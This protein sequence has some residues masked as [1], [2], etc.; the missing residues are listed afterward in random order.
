MS[1]RSSLIIIS[2]FLVAVIFVSGC[3]SSDSG[4]VK[5]CKHSGECVTDCLLDCTP[6]TAEFAGFV[7]GTTVFEIVGPDDGR[8][9][10][11]KN[12]IDADGKETNVD[13]CYIKKGRIIKGE[14]PM[15]TRYAMTDAF[16]DCE[17]T[18]SG[19]LKIGP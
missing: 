12:Y 18:P 16:E 6:A 4:G 14:N 17:K 19:Q 9:I 11:L 2:I 15:V 7:G 8:C 3:E 10:V 13:T 1:T 5:E